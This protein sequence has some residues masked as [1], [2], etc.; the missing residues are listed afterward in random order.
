MHDQIDVCAL[1][2]AT[3]DVEHGGCRGSDRMAVGFI[4]T[5]AISAYHL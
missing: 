2:M 3:S 4:T 1:I 5:S